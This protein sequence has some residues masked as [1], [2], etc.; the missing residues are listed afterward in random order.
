[1]SKAVLEKVHISSYDDI[2]GDVGDGIVEVPLSDL[3]AFRNHP[4][5][6]L[7]DERMEE[8]VE[9][10]RLHGVLTPGIARPRSSG[11]YE[12]ISGHRRKRACEIAGIPSMPVIVRDYTDDE[13]TI[14]MVDANIQRDE[15]LPSEKARAYAMKYEAMKHQGKRSNGT[16][17]EEMS[18]KSNDGAKTIQRYLWLSRLCDGLLS[19][20]DTGRISFL[21]GVELS[22]LSEEEQAWALSLMED[23][24][25][26][27]LAQSS[28]IK[29]YSKIGEL[30]EALLRHILSDV[31]TKAKRF[32]IHAEKIGK[33]FGENASA[34]EIEETIL[35]ALEYYTSHMR[36][37]ES[38]V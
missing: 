8:T 11:G 32:T 5:R 23:G 27:T 6:V 4:F 10:V 25:S 1:M 17:L 9:S 21:C 14:I 38:E 29:E 37:E 20:V 36:R 13:A 24:L 16:A 30:T 12:L 19:F 15:I 18:E 28:Q 34:E 26:I 22:F 31:P 33:Y 7:D 3:H 35:D 2:F